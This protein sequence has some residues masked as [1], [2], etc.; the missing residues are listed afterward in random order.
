MT[1]AADYAGPAIVLAAIFPE[2]TEAKEEEQKPYNPFHPC[3]YS[4]IWMGKPPDDRY[5]FAIALN[6]WYMEEPL[7]IV[8][9][10]PFHGLLVRRDGE[11]THHDIDEL[12][13]HHF[14]EDDRMPEFHS[15]RS[16]LRW[17][18]DIRNWRQIDRH[19][20]KG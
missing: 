16:F 10:A 1:A 5:T 12:R 7:L 6:L 9:T 20:P 18:K 2:L 17:A 19:A 13:T 11:T 3:M 14:R 15:I 8:R 4:D